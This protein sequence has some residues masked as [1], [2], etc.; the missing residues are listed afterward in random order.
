MVVSP[1]YMASGR[2]L[3]ALYGMHGGRYIG[4]KGE[5]GPLYGIGAAF[6]AV[7]WAEAS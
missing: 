6:E 2:H 5:I 1:R 4:E 3:R 7:K